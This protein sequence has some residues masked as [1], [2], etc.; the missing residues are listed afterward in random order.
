[1]A[2]IPRYAYSS[3]LVANVLQKSGLE[4]SQGLF[5]FWMSCT[6][7]KGSSVTGLSFSRWTTMFLLAAYAATRLRLSVVRFRSGLE[8]LASAMLV[9]TLGEPMATATSIH[10]LLKAIA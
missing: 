2:A 9:R 8:S 3:G 4:R 10:F 5:T 7:K 1:M 6:M